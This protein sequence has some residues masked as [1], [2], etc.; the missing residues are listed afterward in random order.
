[1]PALPMPFP[2][3]QTWERFASL[4]KPRHSVQHAPLRYTAVTVEFS[5]SASAIAVAPSGPIS[6]AAHASACCCA[7]RRT[8]TLDVASRTAHVHRGYDCVDEQRSRQLRGAN[9]ADVVVWHPRK[10]RHKP[11]NISVGQAC[12]DL[13]TADKRR[14][15]SFVQHE[16]GC[17][18]RGTSRPN[19]IDWE[20]TSVIRSVTTC[21][22]NSIQTRVRMHA[23][24]AQQQLLHVAVPATL[25]AQVERLD[26]GVEFECPRKCRCARRAYGVTCSGNT[27]YAVSKPA[28]AYGSRM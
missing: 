26:A 7:I 28:R 24:T 17:E 22:C 13:R 12:R 6:L 14:L 9:G 21:L 4:Q 23:S 19:D 3:Q 27:Q 15:Q 16:R 20:R 2:A 25:T 5:A 8:R 11:T 1:M 18:R 10:T